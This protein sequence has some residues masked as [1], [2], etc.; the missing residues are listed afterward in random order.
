M[1]NLT[2][3]LGF[4]ALDAACV[5]A[6]E[7][8]PTKPQLTPAA[9]CARLATGQPVGP[10]EWDPA[11]GENVLAVRDSCAKA[12]GDPEFCPVATSVGLS[13]TD[14]RAPGTLPTDL[15]QDA[16]AQCLENLGPARAPKCD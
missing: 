8:R 6:P 10:G 5:S 13:R 16:R 7:A 12:S 2:L 9:I 4:A 3:A 11:L 1:R 15:A 14:A